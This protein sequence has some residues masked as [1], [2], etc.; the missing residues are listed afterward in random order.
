M[1]KEAK[2]LATQAKSKEQRQ[3]HYLAVKEISTLFRGIT[4]KHYNDFYRL[5]CLHS[6]KTEN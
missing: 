3:C 2:T 1:E 4:C 6:F 5:K